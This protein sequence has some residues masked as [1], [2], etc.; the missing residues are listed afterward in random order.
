MKKKFSM[1]VIASLISMLLLLGMLPVMSVSAEEMTGTTEDGYVY[2]IEDGEATIIDYTADYM[3]VTIPDYVQHYSSG[4]YRSYPVTCIG[5]YAFENSGMYSLQ[6]GNNVK[7]IERYAFFGSSVEIVMISASVEEVEPLAFYCCFSLAYFMVDENNSVLDSREDC[8]DIIET[9]TNTLVAGC[10]NSVIPESVEAIGDYAFM[11]CIDLLNITIPYGVKSLGVGAF[12][13]CSSL[14]YIE[15]PDSITSIENYTFAYCTNMYFAV[16]P[17]NLTKIG[18]MAF[19][20]CTRLTETGIPD[21]VT[22]IGEQ[23]Y[24]NCSSLAS[25]N[26]PYNATKIG[27]EAFAGCSKITELSFPKGITV[28]EERTFEGCES[29]AEISLYWDFEKVNA[30]AFRGCTSLSKVTYSGAPSGWRRVTVDDGN[31]ALL[32]AE[33]ECTFEEAELKGHSLSLGGTIGVNF[34]FK[35]S[36]DIVN[37]PATV[38][39]KCGNYET[40]IGAHNG[41]YM[42]D[43][44]TQRF[45]INIPAKEMTSEITCQVF[46]PYFNYKSDVFTYSI[47]E[48]ADDVLSEPEKYDEKTINLVKSMLNYGAAT[49][50][51]FNNDT[52]NLANDTEYMTD[53]DKTVPQKDFSSLGYTLTEGN[54]D[55]QYY[56]STLSLKGRIEIKH[57]FILKEGISVEDLVVTV[58]SKKATL[59]KNGD[60]Y[61]LSIPD[62]FTHKVYDKYETQVGDVSLSYCVMDYAAVAQKTGNEKLMNVMYA[63]DAYAQSAIAYIEN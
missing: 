61:E 29:L 12:G 23:A 7:R 33:V 10:K 56:G 39:L 49:Q 24:M 53:E 30:D 37:G 3:S 34:F 31:D 42:E 35:L 36:K 43:N 62:V 21:N 28:I 16:M 46:C 59:K 14:N 9:A 18:D 6:I 22:E 40:V 41:L 4:E 26:I 8:S 47:G 51:Y 63:L 38:V 20:N 52:D 19:Y 13:E 57:Y 55:V 60:L 17:Y 50:L 27:A 5:S 48:Y 11:G 44:I 15:I 32:N 1:R 58:N 25:I 45:T 54:G 2:S